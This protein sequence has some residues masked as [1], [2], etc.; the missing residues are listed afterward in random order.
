LDNIELV[1]TGDKWIGNGIRSFNSRIIEIISESKK[2]LLM[3][4]Y[5]ISEPLIVKKIEERLEKGVSVEMYVNYDEKNLRLFWE[6][7]DLEKKYPYFK[8]K[9]IKG[10]VLH[11]KIIVS[12]RKKVLM[13]SANLTYSGMLK[14]YEMG[15]EIENTE[16]SQKI[17]EMLRGI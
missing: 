8:I 13:G 14:N 7:K 9:I 1:A 10:A 12:D 4:A 11:A 17:I 3:T 16:I 6:L 5:S 2:H 15:L